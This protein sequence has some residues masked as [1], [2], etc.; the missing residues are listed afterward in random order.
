MF[1][2]NSGVSIISIIFVI[3]GCNDF[4]TQLTC[5]IAVISTTCVTLV[6]FLVL[7]NTDGVILLLDFWVVLFVLC[8]AEVWWRCYFVTTFG[9]L[10]SVT[11]NLHL[12]LLFQFTDQLF[13]LL[14]CCFFNVWL[15]W[16]FKLSL[17]SF[18]RGNRG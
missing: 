6:L 14:R 4:S 3:L 16:C 9:I 1:N 5:S 17:F 8:I 18:L 12:S 7:F 15:T 11:S 2:G 10:L 13:H